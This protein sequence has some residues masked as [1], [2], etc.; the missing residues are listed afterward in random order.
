[1]IQPRLKEVL[2]ENGKTLYWLA[3]QTEI[4]YS[5]LYKFSK[6]L[7]QS[8]DYRVLDEICDALN[9]QPGDL[10]VRIAGEHKTGRGKARERSA[11]GGAAK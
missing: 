10:L 4:H 11:K 8:V 5:T 6:S 3:K 1:M 7:T 2:L 9:C